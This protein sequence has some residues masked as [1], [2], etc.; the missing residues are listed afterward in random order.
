MLPAPLVLRPAITAR[1]G[2]HHWPGASLT[3]ASGGSHNA[4]MS[5]AARS[6]LETELRRLDKRVDELVAVIAQLKEENR[7]LRARQDAMNSERTA[8]LQKNEQVKARVEAMIGRL[9]SME[10]GA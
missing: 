4:A 6:A 5:D 2:R 7:A 10:H 9:K 8:L 1:A 3:G